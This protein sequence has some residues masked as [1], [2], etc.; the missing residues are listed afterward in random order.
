MH[1]LHSKPP[2]PR[3]RPVN[4]FKALKRYYNEI[5]SNQQNEIQLLKAELAAWGHP[6]YQEAGSI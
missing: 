5:I 1:S 2:I 3:K 4:A 6:Y